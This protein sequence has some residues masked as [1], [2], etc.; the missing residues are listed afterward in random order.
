MSLRSTV[1]ARA[2]RT[3]SRPARPHCG[4]EGEH[5]RFSPSCQ[6][7]PFPSG[8]ASRVRVSDALVLPPGRPKRISKSGLLPRRGMH[9]APAYPAPGQSVALTETVSTNQTST[10]PPPPGSGARPNCRDVIANQIFHR[11]WIKFVCGR[12]HPR[13]SPGGGGDSQEGVSPPLVRPSRAATLSSSYELAH[14]ARRV[15]APQPV[16]KTDTRIIALAALPPKNKQ[17]HAGAPPAKIKETL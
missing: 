4:Q 16:K 1:C 3:G 9:R 5:L 15:G 14:S 12:G 7:T 2:S 8:R 10:A 6:S 17:H 11:V 13:T